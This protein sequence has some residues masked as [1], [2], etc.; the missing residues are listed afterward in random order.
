[1]P[2]QRLPRLAVREANDPCYEEKSSLRQKV[3]R[4]AKRLIFNL[5]EAVDGLKSRLFFEKIAVIR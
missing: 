1:M 2:G 4:W 3:H 5:F